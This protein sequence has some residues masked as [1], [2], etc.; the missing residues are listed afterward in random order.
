ML[1]PIVGIA[2]GQDV[3][4]TLRPHCNSDIFGIEHIGG[5]VPFNDEYEMG[6]DGC[7]NFVVED[8]ETI[9]TDMLEVGDEL[10]FDISISNPNLQSV[11]SVRVWLSYDPVILEG[12]NINV[13]DSFPAVTPGESDFDTENGYV[14]I[15]ARND[16]ENSNEDD[17]IKVARVRFLVK[18]TSSA[19]TPISFYDPQDGGHTSISSNINEVETYILSDPLGSLHVVF[20]NNDLDEEDEGG[21]TE[22]DNEESENNDDVEGDNDVD[23]LFEEDG[24][25]LDGDN[26]E[27]QQEEESN[28]ENDNN[29]QEEENEGSEEDNSNQRTPFSLLQ[30]RNIRITT[31]G[32]SLY[33]GWD[34]INHS[35]VK[36][37]NIY[38]GTTS[39]RYIQRKTVNGS[40]DSLIIRS[41][42]INTTYFVAVRAVSDDDEESAFSQEASVTIG[43]SNTSTAQLITNPGPNGVNPLQNEYNVPGETGLPSKI[44]LFVFLSAIIGTVVALRRQSAYATC[45]K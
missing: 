38:Y 9:K 32:S 27:E 22:E 16:T 33:I 10:D 28:E 1:V 11:D 3:S 24:E 36:A 40:M 41:L 13:S 26:N 42:P 25:E 29:Q 35:S 30:V 21:T 45:K 44:A 8:P 5:S 7:P 6:E 15:E 31:E 18:E 4:L 39:G 14:M 23:A 19:G 37:Y 12:I 34:S 2:A 20:S 43:D 17:T